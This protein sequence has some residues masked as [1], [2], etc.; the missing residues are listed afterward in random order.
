MTYTNKTQQLLDKLQLD[1]PLIQAPMVGVSSPP[2]AAAAASRGALGSLGLSGGSA[3]AVENAYAAVS[4][5]SQQPVNLNFFC[6]A[7]P[8]GNDTKQTQW[9]QY[10][11]PLFA[12]LGANAPKKIAAPYGTFD[13]E[14]ETLAALL[15]CNAAIV[16]FHFGLPA[17]ASVQALRDNGTFVLASATSITEA[18]WLVAVGVDAV[19]A[20]GWEAGGH[21]GRF[22][23][24]QQDEQL[25]TL[26]LVQQLTQDLDVP[27]IAAGGINDG[28]S[29]AAA[30]TLGAAAVQMGT[31]FVS[32]PESMASK[33]YRAALAQPH[34]QSIMTTVFSGRESRGLKNR[35]TEV[36][37]PF[38]ALA[39]DYPIAYDAGK[40]LA[41]A[42]AVTQS[43][44]HIQNY[45]PLW[46]G[47]GF[48]H[49]RSLPAAELVT[50]IVE[51]LANAES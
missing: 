30:L 28:T 51:E 26:L 6:H 4:K 44:Q 5:L 49:N 3:A 43:E 13:D 34:R 46:A 45:S 50:Q 10:L 11:K 23:T 35:V 33:A 27:I 19:I 15:D 22:A 39:P 8:T 2:L 17:Q 42:A 25:S 29:A 9:L 48:R 40:A 7:R 12:E 14:P 38:A 36:L 20:Q 37:D 31:A 32:C 41:A 24:D 21:R 18:K 47:E 16:S 1:H